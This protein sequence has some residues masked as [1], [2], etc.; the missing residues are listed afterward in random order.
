MAEK[1]HRVIII[2]SLKEGRVPM[3][4]E[5]ANIVKIFKGGN[6]D[7]TSNYS[8]V[9]LTSVVVKICKRVIKDKWIKNLEENSV[10]TNRQFG[11]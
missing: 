8:P 3:D 10:L 7:K 5:R 2:H 11:F 6:K 9:S 1:V 4:C